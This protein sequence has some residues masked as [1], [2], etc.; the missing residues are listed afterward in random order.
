MEAQY[1]NRR[2]GEIKGERENKLIIEGKNEGK[3]EAGRTN[4][5]IESRKQGRKGEGR[6]GGR[7][8]CCFLN[9]WSLELA[10]DG[11]PN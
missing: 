5:I 7:V 8:T 2:K 1:K 11:H 4:K 10:A 3:E 6:V 9:G